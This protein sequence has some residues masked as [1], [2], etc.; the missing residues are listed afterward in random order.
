MSASAPRTK[1]DAAQAE[2][3]A[4]AERDDERA[5]KEAPK[6]A[7][8]AP[9]PPEDAP[10]SFSRNRPVR[11]GMA[12]VGVALLASLAPIDHWAGWVARGLAFGALAVSTYVVGTR[13]LDLRIVQVEID[14]LDGDEVDRYVAAPRAVLADIGDVEDHAFRSN[15]LL[16]KVRTPYP[17][18]FVVD[19][20]GQLDL[21]LSRQR[22][23]DRVRASA[24][25]ATAALTIEVR[26]TAAPHSDVRIPAADVEV[27]ADA[28]GAFHAGIPF[29]VVKRFEDRG[30]IPA[31]WRRE[32]VK[33][34]VRIPIPS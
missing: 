28:A 11:V 19:R 9:P 12:L 16:L 13:Y 32:G 14:Q 21:P 26:G 7:P 20:L 30:F 33:Q 3:A 24:L 8:P 4:A 18:G 1:Q 29:E 27:H 5:A 15:R 23:A 22:T 10:P 2:R 31:E 17:S 25:Q 6:K 34:E